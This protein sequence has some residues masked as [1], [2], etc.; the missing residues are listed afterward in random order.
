[1][2]SGGILSSA[3]ITNPGSGYTHSNPPVCLI[4]SPEITEEDMA[5]IS[6]LGD[7]GQIVGVG[8]TSNGS[9]NQLTFDFFIPVNSDLRNTNLVG[10]AITIS[11]I[12]TNDY[13]TISNT[14]ISIGDTFASEDT[15]GTKIGIGTT[16][17]DMVYQVVSSETRDENVT[18][19]GTTSIRRIVVNIDTA[20]GFAFTNTSNMGNYSWGKIKV[21]RELIPSQFNFYGD[22][23]LIGI[24]TSA[25][26][27]RFNPL[28]F[29]NYV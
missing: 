5:V 17:L 10:T 27:T 3:S 6:Y 18:G 22:N 14:N 25:L 20:A 28:K 29:N 2:T 7:Y 15:S 24:S 16:A 13:L 26:V 12:S 11:G 19:I 21:S 23:G 9:Q 4:K 8:T 1:M